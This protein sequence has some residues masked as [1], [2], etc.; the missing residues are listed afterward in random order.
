MLFM[1][2]WGLQSKVTSEPGG[3]ESQDGFIL[4]LATPTFYILVIVQNILSTK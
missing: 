1:R 3:V 2:G 4:V